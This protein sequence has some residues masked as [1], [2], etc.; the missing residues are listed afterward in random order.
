MA[1]TV[2]TIVEELLKKNH[3]SNRKAFGCGVFYTVHP[4]GTGNQNV[5]AV[6]G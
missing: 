4:E 6:S 3:A 1:T 5:A 2:D